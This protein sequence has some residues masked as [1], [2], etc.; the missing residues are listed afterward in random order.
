MPYYLVIRN[1]IRG[2]I[3]IYKQESSGLHPELFLF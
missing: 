1:I 2:T 3:L